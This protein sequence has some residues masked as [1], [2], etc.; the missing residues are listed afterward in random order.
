MESVPKSAPV[1]ITSTL[2]E[3]SMC[4]RSEERRVGKE[5][6]ITFISRWSLF[7]LKKKFIFFYKQKTRYEMRISDWS[8]DV[9]S[10]DLASPHENFAVSHT[11]I[12]NNNCATCNIV[13]KE[14]MNVRTV[15]GGYR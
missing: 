11:Y 2:M 12:M 15:E 5:C 14:I 3:S 4:T 1:Y 10:S 13:A 7:L 6:F 8:S 9:C